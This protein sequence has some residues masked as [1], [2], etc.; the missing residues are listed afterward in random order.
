[1]TEDEVGKIEPD[2]IASINVIKGKPAIDRYGEKGKD[3]VLEISTKKNQAGDKM[4]VVP[5][6]PPPP[7][8][9][10]NFDIRSEN[11]AKPLFV[12]DGIVEGKDF[13]VKSINPEDI[14]KIEVLKD[15]S[16]VE[17]YGGKAEN[18]VV[19]ITSKKTTSAV[20]STK[21]EVTVT[22]YADNKADKSFVV[23]EQMPM[24]P[25]GE[26]AMVTWIT[27]NLKY[28]G[29]AVKDKIE[30]NVPVNFLVTRTGK[31]KDVKV[32]KSVNPL[33]D[34]EAVRVISS[35]PDWKPG[36]QAGKLVDVQMQVPV[37][38]KLK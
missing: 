22:G 9:F 8:P 13:D 2:V 15:K 16:A 38:F 14:E 31:I 19:I 7:A 30:G 17:L 6:P 12:V 24:F 37:E 10:P 34:E 21:S 33:L 20:N 35:M 26:N 1:M 5:P 11:G 25:G 23:I 32:L 29:K 28:P 3:G 27:T 4:E 18:G 36:S